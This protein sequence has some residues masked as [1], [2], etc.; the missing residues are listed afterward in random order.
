[1]LASHLEWCWAPSKQQAGDAATFH[2]LVRPLKGRICNK[3]VIITQMKGRKKAEN[4][5]G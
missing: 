1:M 5:R 4:A 3:C 2:A